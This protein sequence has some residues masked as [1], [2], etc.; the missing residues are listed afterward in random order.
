M[1][2]PIDSVPFLLLNAAFLL[3]VALLVFVYRTRWVRVQKRYQE[4]QKRYHSAAIATEASPHGLV[5]LI[6]RKE[7]TLKGQGLSCIANRTL[8]EKFG[9]DGGEIDFL[10]VATI[11]NRDNQRHRLLEAA[12]TLLAE[13][14]AFDFTLSTKGRTY[15]VVGTRGR[16]R[17][18]GKC[19][20]IWFQDV[21]PQNQLYLESEKRAEQ[22]SDLLNSMPCPLWMR[23]GDH[24][25]LYC[26][27]SYCKV[28]GLEEE[29]VL[30]TGAEFL[31]R[32][33]QKE[34]QTLTEE[35]MRSRDFVEKDYPVIV[36]G[37]RR[38]YRV[39]EKALSAD[40]VLGFAQDLTERQDLQNLLTQHEQTQALLLENLRISIAVYNAD[41]RLCFSNTAFANLHHLSDD[42]IDSMPSFGEVLD[43]MREKRRVPEYANFLEFK[44][45]RTRAMEVLT[46]PEEELSHLPDGSTLR[47]VSYPHPFGGIIQTVEDVT[48]RL[49][50][51]RSFNTLLEVQ[52]QTLDKLYEA[53]AVYGADG[54]L[55]LFNPNFSQIWNLSP[56]FLSKGPHIRQVLE[57]GRR[58]FEIPDDK[59]WDQKL[60]RMVRQTLDATSRSDR[61]E[62]RDGR[63]LDWSQEPL[64]DGSSLLTFLDVTDATK[65]ERA[66]LEKNEALQTADRLKSE[67][68]ANVSYE[69][70]TPLNAIVGFAEILDNQFF[71]ALNNRQTEYSRAIVESSRRLM[72]LINDILD[73]ST[74]EAGYLTLEL[75]PVLVSK[76]MENLFTMAHERARNNGVNL[77]L[78]CTPDVGEVVLDEHR[79]TQVL[80]NLVFN[81]IKFS[82]KDEE[83]KIS[84]SLQGENLLLQVEDSGVGIAPA[85][86]KR[87]FKKFERGSNVSKH[88]GAGLGLSL[89]RSLVELHGGFV[90][91]DSDLERGTAVRC[92][93]PLGATAGLYEA[94]GDF[95][96][97]PEGRSFFGYCAASKRTENSFTPEDKKR[98]VTVGEDERLLQAA[99]SFIQ[100]IKA[101][102]PSKE[103][104]S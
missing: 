65:V 98:K 5:Y 85:D 101:R 56:D 81:S 50:L 10:A 47:V 80:L 49:A 62:R 75:R 82:K 42:F 54:R 84:A 28:V 35:A 1:S 63:V 52:R 43:H 9:L 55:K 23:N 95:L 61:L 36:D 33:S 27:D 17:P 16:S 38:F 31:G 19:D 12:N 76:M 7:G 18:L 29:E 24:T 99:Q 44:R 15:E 66:L 79:I 67:F 64:P 89:V 71:G 78:S 86:Q 22:L 41:M 8:Q 59:E 48:D 104:K 92:F 69:L 34:A 91:L 13:G 97:T 73:L 26:N 32:S 6:R 40:I 45:Q 68:I 77:V 3:G 21:T 90:S 20:A 103:K 4:F 88:T 74:I 102:A 100:E 53:V 30:A 25:L 72:T 94:Q 14:K 93:L 51:E 37:E 46:G 2:L 58:Y 39:S 60:Q 57:N 11:F 70:R 96:P 83:V 87:V